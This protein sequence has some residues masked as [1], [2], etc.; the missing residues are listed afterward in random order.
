MVWVAVAILADT[1]I[2]SVVTKGDD[3]PDIWKYT[4]H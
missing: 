1:D 3:L 2:L 4:K